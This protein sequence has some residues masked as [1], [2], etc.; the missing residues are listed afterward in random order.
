[1]KPHS[2][3]QHKSAARILRSE[4]EINHTATPYP[5]ISCSPAGLR[6]NTTIHLDRPKRT[7]SLIDG[8]NMFEPRDSMSRTSATPR[9]RRPRV[10]PELPSCRYR[11]SPD[12]RS[13]S[14]P[15]H[16]A[17]EKTPVAP[18]TLVTRVSVES[19]SDDTSDA[20]GIILVAGGFVDYWRSGCEVPWAVLVGLIC[21]DPPW[22]ARWALLME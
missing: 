18:L 14:E 15:T 13:A 1:V 5:A 3:H 6:P 20:I 2:K 8:E 12:R 19:P 10:T 7:L 16:A 22:E 11:I 17:S 9:T 21:P 4:L